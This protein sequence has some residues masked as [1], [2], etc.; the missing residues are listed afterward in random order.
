MMVNRDIQ[1][2]E[3][4]P[5][6]V[7]ISSHDENIIEVNQAFVEI[8]GYKSKEEFLKS[9]SLDFYANNEERDKFRNKLKKGFVKNLRIKGKRKDGSIVWL[10]L[11][12]NLINT[13]NGSE[14]FITIVED[15]TEQVET[16]DKIVQFNKIFEESLN[17]IYI[18]DAK[19][20][21]FLEV[22]QAAQNNLG[23]SIDELL[24]ITPL[25]IKPDFTYNS[26]KELILPLTSG[27]DEKILFYTHHKRKNNSLYKVEVHLQLSTF[28]NR[29]SYTAIILDIT[30]RDKAEK[31]LILS[32]EKYKAIIEGQTEFIYRWKPDGTR[33]FVNKAYADYYN[34]TVDELTGTTFVD[35]INPDAWTQLQ[36][37]ISKLSIIN[38]VSKNEHESI[39][40][41]KTIWK[42]WTDRALFDENGKLYEIQSTGRDI[43]QKKLAEQK[44]I[45]NEIKFRNIFNSANDSIFLF[46]DGFFV[47][48]N[49]KTTELFKCT[50]DQIIGKPPTILFPDKQPDG[51]NSLKKISKKIGAALAGKPQLFEWTHKKL[52]ST[53]FAAEVSLNKMEL[54]DG[55]YVQAIVRDITERKKSEEE[56]RSSEER[57][58]IIFENA[59]D[60][61]F[62]SDLKGNTIDV[63]KYTEKML[64]LSK[65]EIVNKNFLQL[66]IVSLK[67]LPKAVALMA[68]TIQG[69]SSK[70][71]ELQMSKPDGTKIISELRMFPVKLN[72]KVHL[73]GTGRDITEKKISERK[74]VESEERY[75]ALFEESSD[76]TLLIEDEVFIECNDATVSYL[77]YKNKK[78]LIGKTPWDISPEFQPDRQN[79]KDKANE[80]IQLVL[81]NGN[82]RFDWVHKDKNDHNL[83]IDV[84]LTLIPG[85]DKNR[86]YTVWRD[87]TLQREA[88][89][90]LVENQSLLRATL[91]STGEG[92]LVVNNEGEV[93]H[94]NSNFLKIWN[95]P[96]SLIETKNDK[97][98]LDFVLS[99]LVNPQEFIDKVKQLYKSDKIDYD[100]IEFIDSRKIER[101]SF[102]LLIEN[103]VEGRVWSFNDVTAQFEAQKNI[104]ESE[105]R[106]KQ[107]I[108]NLPDAI[109]VTVLGGKNKGKIIETNPAAES[110]T[111]YSREELL[112]KRI[113][114]DLLES[115]DEDKFLRDEKE[116]IKSGI[117]RFT[118]KK[119]RKDGTVYW[120]E[121]IITTIILKGEKVA[122]AVN[123]DISELIKS[124]QALK[125]SQKNLSLIYDTAGVGL[126][127]ISVGPENKFSI[128]SVNNTYLQITGRKINEVINLPIEEVLSHESV[129]IAIEKYTQAIKN[130]KTISW[131][132]TSILP[133][134][135]ISGALSVTPVFS[136]DE[137]CT[138]LIGVVHD[139][140]EKKKIEAQI[141][142]SQ[143]E[144]EKLVN[145]RTVDLDKSRKAAMNLLQD[146]N[147]QRKRAENALQSLK[148]S[149]TE[150][151]KLSQAVEQN[152]A[153]VFIIDT[154]GNIEYVN[155]NFTEKTGYTFI[156]IS[157]KQPKVKLFSNTLPTERKDVWSKINKGETWSGEIK[158]IPKKG[159]A[160]WESISI[161]PLYDENKSIISFIRV[162]QDITQRKKLEEDLLIAKEKADEAT[163]AKSEFL[164]NMSHEI[165]TPMNAILGFAD[166]LSVSITESHAKNYLNSLKT[167]GKSLLNL[168]NDI[169]D[170]SK[171]EAGMLQLSYEF[172][173][174]R[175]LFE[176]IHQMFSIEIAG[177]KIDFILEIDKSLPNAVFLDEARLRQILINLVSNAVK[178][179]EKGHIKLIARPEK[180]FKVPDHKKNFSINL[181]VEVEDTGIGISEEF[182]EIIFDSFTQH[183]GHDTKKHGGTGLGLSISQNLV[184]LMNGRISLKSGLAK[185]STFS[186]LLKNTLVTTTHVL[187]KKSEQ[188]GL[189]DIA[190]EP[191]TVLIV[192][193]VYNNLVFISGILEYAGFK[194]LQALNGEEAIHALKNNK[195]DLII[196]DIRMPVM[197]GAELLHYIRQSDEFKNIPVI[198]STTSTLKNDVLKNNESDFD[199][200]ISKP[201]QIPEL[202]LELT[203]HIKHKVIRSASNESVEFEYNIGNI[204]AEN[205]PIVIDRIENELMPLWEEIR[206]RQPVKKVELFGNKLIKIGTLYKING[207]ILYGNDIV[208]AIKS[209][210][211]EGIVKL[212]KLFPDLINKLRL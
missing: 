52:D 68:D 175:L 80:M 45:E 111:G 24:I 128:L 208:D 189:N 53:T 120:V 134:G 64:G 167:S 79:S 58:K 191:S 144:L 135:K 138:S 2:F 51:S 184:K 114:E 153:A 155:R 100:V 40:N 147:E 163:K 194:V 183:E 207:F 113:G 26:F 195:P 112:K 12:T 62:L 170:L 212:I 102:P 75:R 125:D 61:Y 93:T 33:T 49:S 65:N 117:L 85:D 173:D 202:L 210:N 193:D 174:L 37:R 14:K 103:S 67:D 187:K 11:S 190:F 196:T 197:D 180:P 201:I 145:S 54:S 127:R 166:L 55:I 126:F 57:L 168:I 136:E 110:Q 92:I 151:R 186:V 149:H 132:E 171:V 133:S 89:I 143:T 185:G 30:E 161:S 27:Q 10:S 71:L 5:A 181:I 41:G 109:F 95:I 101:R 131:E 198:C 200:Y 148:K 69:K 211:I 165:R 105:H 73:L 78:E 88:E 104:K 47:D 99:Q 76:P 107:V 142:K 192:D 139:I 122:L 22:N 42:E 116:L 98:L 164:A 4:L 3:N 21:K 72:G 203:N 157:G 83:W 18:F 86:I 29:Q 15:I 31:A 19:T 38:P 162:G 123:R 63:N 17:E 7:L 36:K 96:D 66:G 108:E 169:L 91:E 25:D 205:I 178:F 140:S 204:A 119:R 177:K 118:E 44:L 130:K 209:F 77:K 152:P 46:K 23:Y 188:L 35:T 20:F 182:Q 129:K 124:E 34:K 115:L 82:H 87:I 90:K 159:D 199:G 56:I 84:S 48:C 8:L 59:P 179:T 39:I 158:S 60:A 154:N 106:F 1:L 50:R 6:G 160:F 137:I 81:K 176:D 9:K 16:Q 43:T 121:V 28:N 146:S 13:D 94:F 172:I 206:T 156:E 141:I 32:E 70:P 150:I 97:K 74:I